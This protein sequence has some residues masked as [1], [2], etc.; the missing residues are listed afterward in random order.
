M[1]RTGGAR[2]HVI[3]SSAALSIGRGGEGRSQCVGT[4]SLHSRIPA[5]EVLR[6]NGRGRDAY[7]SSSNRATSQSWFDQIEGQTRICVPSFGALSI[8]CQ[9]VTFVLS[10]RGGV[11]G[12]ARRE[13]RSVWRSGRRC[14]RQLTRRLRTYLCRQ[15]RVLLPRV[16]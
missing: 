6:Q 9:L 1:F 15:C 4:F 11:M 16:N 8:V 10:A 12:M 3:P 13:G 14:A 7:L 5:G 2:A